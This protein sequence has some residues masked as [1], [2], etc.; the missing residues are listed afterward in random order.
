MS[1]SGEMTAVRLPAEA[2]TPQGPQPA[3]KVDHELAAVISMAQAATSRFGSAGT[4]LGA[5]LQD[6]R[7]AW[8]VAGNML[9][10]G[11]RQ[12]R[13][14]KR[15]QAAPSAPSSP[16]KIAVNGQHYLVE[17]SDLG[18]SPVPVKANGQ[19]YQVTFACDQH[20]GTPAN[21][22]GQ[23][24]RPSS[25]ASARAVSASRARRA[26]AGAS[27]LR[28][29]KTPMPGT[30]LGIAIKPG[31]KVTARQILC[32][33][34]AMKMKNAI[35]APRDGVIASVDVRDGQ[36]VAKGDILFTFE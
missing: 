3:P 28:H 26:S 22:P 34:E 27:E 24:T 13:M 14:P 25:P 1:E 11:T 6:G 29:V 30:I 20:Q 15:A 33:L 32:W 2:T 16:I 5:A 7:G 9:N 36:T 17:V 4:G 18:A 8:W 23:E 10:E 35:R 12:W 19:R 21:A 31:D